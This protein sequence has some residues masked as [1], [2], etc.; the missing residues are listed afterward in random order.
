MSADKRNKPDAFEK[1]GAASLLPPPENGDACL[2]SERYR[3]FFEDVADGFY[4]TDLHGHFRFLNAAFTRIFGYPAED[5]LGRS[6]R[7][8]MDERSAR[9][10]FED[11]NRIYRTGRDIDHA[12]WE[13]TREDGQTRVLE[14]SARLIKDENGQRL[15]FRGIARDVTEKHRAQQALRASEQRAHQQY[16][17]SRRAERL[18]RSLLDFLPDPVFVFNLDSTV[19]Y[20]NPAFVKVFGWSLEE[21]EG[22]KIPFVPDFLKEETRQGI[23]RLFE[24]KVIYNFETKR[25]TRDGRLLDIILNGALFYDKDNQPAGQVIV[26]RDVTREKRNTRINQTLFRI[27]KALHQFPGLDARLGFIAKEVQELLGVEGALVILIDGAKQEFFFRAAAHEESE[28]EKRFIE[29]RFPLDKGVAGEVYRTGKPLI[30]PDTSQSPHFFNKV[31]EKTGLRTRNMLDVPIQTQEQMIGVLCAVNKKEGPFDETDVELAAAVASMVAL[32]IENARIN[33]ALKH[34]YEEV[35]SLNRAKDRVIH[36]LSHE[37]KTPVS[38][39][40]ASLGLLSRQLTRGGADRDESLQRILQRAE[41]NLQRILHMQYEIEDILRGRDY[42]SHRMLS[43]LLEV[44]QDEL[45]ALVDEDGGGAVAGR[46][47]AKIDELFGPKEAL[48][49]PVRLDRFVTQVVAEQRP[50]FG[51]RQCELRLETSP[52][53]EVNIPPEVLR[54]VVAGLVR[55]A[56]ENTPDGGRIEVTVRPGPRGPELVVTDCGVGITE[57][58]RPLIFESYFSTAETMQYAS[59]RPFDFNAGG[60]GFDLLRMKI[61]SERYHFEIGMET[62]RCRHIPR[63]EDLCPGDVSRCPFCRKAADCLTS[64]GTSMHVVF[65]LN[66]GSNDPAGSSRR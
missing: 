48:S 10:A 26:L 4:E 5:M 49:R 33:E 11:F 65:P 9:L 12:R 25:L 36:H 57:I 17:A 47:R 58:N 42:R 32:P 8:F 24:E 14:I 60:K 19:A 39:L 1:T 45:E 37:L 15:G 23:H 38:V 2:Q 53:R 41:R 6:F 7:D 52:T 44:C 55:N 18:Y 30:V 43:G 13:I 22:K 54:K 35:K 28:A 29:T 66:G 20:L 61:F 51:H 34:S 59:R 21:L 46:I 63:D 56:V 62:R 50:Q 31:D 40:S 64:G 16:L 3:L 27:A